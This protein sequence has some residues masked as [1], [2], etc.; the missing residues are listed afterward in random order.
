[1]LI[2]NPYSIG[3][4]VHN[5]SLFLFDSH[6]HGHKSALLAT[7]PCAHGTAYVKSLSAKVLWFYPSVEYV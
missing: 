5:T 2:I 4:G 1:M 6:S 3:V 7:A